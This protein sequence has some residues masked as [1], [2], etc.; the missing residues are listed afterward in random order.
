M[1][2]QV[3]L[4]HSMAEVTG[5]IL[6]NNQQSRGGHVGSSRRQAKKRQAKKTK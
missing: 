6:T 5:A 2:L 1:K 3:Q 4:L